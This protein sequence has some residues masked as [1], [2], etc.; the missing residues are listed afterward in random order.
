L[1]FNALDLMP[2]C[3]ALLAIQLRCPRAGYPPMSAVHN[4]GHHLQIAQQ[5][6]G[7]GRGSFHFLPLR[8]EK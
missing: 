1:V 6:G 3:F 2:R 5:F 7:C 8:L 4:R